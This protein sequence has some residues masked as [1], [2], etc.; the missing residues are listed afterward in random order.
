MRAFKKSGGC[1]GTYVQTLR[2][3]LCPVHSIG[4]HIGSER[5]PNSRQLH[6]GVGERVCSTSDGPVK[7]VL[8]LKAAS[9]R[10]DCDQDIWVARGSRLLEHDPGLGIGAGIRLRPDARDECSI[11]V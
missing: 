6:P 2:Y 4:G 9:S 8:D 3:N 7:V 11:A 5:G 10:S 1:D